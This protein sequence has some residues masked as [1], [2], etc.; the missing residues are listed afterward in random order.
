MSLSYGV[1]SDQ[2]L[3][4]S[5]S[6]AY[7]LT[8]AYD[9][10]TGTK[11]LHTEGISEVALYIS[12]TTGAGGAGNS[13][14]LRLQGSPDL[15]TATPTFYRDIT[16]SSAAG[17][18]TCS[19]AAYSMT[20]AAAGTEYT[21]RILVPVADRQLQFSVKETVVGGA[22]GTLTVRGLLSGKV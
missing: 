8:A 11:V 4:G 17:T 12:Y 21:Y 19:Q 3:I 18:I 9:A 2:Y 20:G 15:I 13:L 14:Q 16:T 7:T 5:A 6:A 1:Q 22:A 10:A